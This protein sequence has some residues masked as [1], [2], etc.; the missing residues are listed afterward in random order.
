MACGRMALLVI[1][2]GLF[3][4]DWAHADKLVVFQNGRTL[5]V[6]D[7]RD[8]GDWLYLTLG[9]RSE[10]GVLS[11]LILAVNDIDSLE[12]GE[13]SPVPNVQS[14]AGGPGRGPA[15]GTRA[16]ATQRGRTAGTRQGGASVPVNAQTEVA[17]RAR[18]DAL[19]RAARR[20]S[21][22][23]VGRVPPSG[24][25]LEPSAAGPGA[26][27]AGGA[28]SSGWRSLLDNSGRGRGST[29]DSGSPRQ[30]DEHPRR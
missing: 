24:T 7:V 30:A 21:T 12:D 1:L 28:A 5:R 10:M 6:V 19:A 3:L 26:D 22:G 17:S 11:R 8:E 29:R 9:K 16:A 27:V 20:T 15:A 18:S 13:S 4:G 25:A 23:R 2:F 14:P